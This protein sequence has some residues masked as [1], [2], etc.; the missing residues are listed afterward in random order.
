MDEYTYHHY[1][2]AINKQMKKLQ[3]FPYNK[4]YKQEDTST[5]SQ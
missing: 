2:T 3:L 5:S 4:H 1:K